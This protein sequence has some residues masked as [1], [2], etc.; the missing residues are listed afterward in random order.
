MF[1]IGELSSTTGCPIETIRY[2]EK[3]KLLQEPPRTDGG[4][5]LYNHHHQQR[6][7]FILRA[8]SLG[9]TLEKTRDLLSL[10]VDNHRSCSEALALVEC[11]L[12]EVNDKIAALQRIKDSLS[13]MAR[14]CRSCCSSAKA[15]DCTIVDALTTQ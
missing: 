7:N 4:H 5:R 8:R 2:Y 11:N 12:A 9:F 15:P 13:L 10:S 1:G 14:S 3:Q 6:L